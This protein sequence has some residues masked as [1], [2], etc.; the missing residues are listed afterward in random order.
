MGQLI[1]LVNFDQCLIA[2]ARCS[3]QAFVDVGGSS[4]TMY[5]SASISSIQSGDRALR[6]ITPFMATQ[7]TTVTSANSYFPFP[8]A[9]SDTSIPYS[10]TSITN[11]IGNCSIAV[12][13]TATGWIANITITGSGLQDETVNSLLFTKSL[14][15]GSSL[16]EALLFAYILDN[17][18]TLNAENNYT[19]NLTMSVSFE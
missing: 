6:N 18:I 14:H 5:C 3:S 10:Q 2:G 19:A 11:Q 13:R 9:S 8:Y 15:T 16:Y 12:T 1:K 4:R 7:D 17:P